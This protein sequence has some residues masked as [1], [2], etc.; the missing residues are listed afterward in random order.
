[1]QKEA[2]AVP[3][4]LFSIWAPVCISDSYWDSDVENLTPCITPVF[5]NMYQL[6]LTV[7]ITFYSLFFPRYQKDWSE[8]QSYTTETAKK[9]E[10]RL[11][12]TCVVVCVC[13][14]I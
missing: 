6:Y 9:A 11:Y 2:M 3:S 8:L 12:Y 14:C 5:E 1:M 10:V 13:V 4:I 7:L